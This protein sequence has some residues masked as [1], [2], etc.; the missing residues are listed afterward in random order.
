[1]LSEY[2]PPGVIINDE[3][4]VVQFRGKTA[5]YLELAPGRAS[6]NLLKML[7]EGLL[8]EVRNSV[9]QVK[10]SG[11]LVRKYCIPTKQS[12]GFRDV[13]LEVVQ[14]QPTT[15]GRHFL[16]L[17]RDSAGAAAASGKAR[18][19]KAVKDPPDQMQQE[20]IAT[21][22]YLQSIIEEQEATN[23]ELQSANEEILSS[24]EELQSINEE[25]ETAREELQSTNEELTT[26]NE[27][28]QNRNAELSQSNDDLN[29][30]LS[31]VNIA[32]VMLSSDLR[33]RRFTP[34]AGRI[35]NLIPSDIGRPITDLRS[36]IYLPELGDLIAEVLDSVTPKELEL[37]DTDGH[38][39]SLAIRPYRTSDNR[40][41]GA[42]LTL[43][44]IESIRRVGDPRPAYREFVQELVDTSEDPMAVVDEGYQVQ[45]ANPAFRA[46]V[47]VDATEGRSFP[48]DQNLKS[49]VEQ[50]ARGPVEPSPVPIELPVGERRLTVR[51]HTLP[52]VEGRE[53]LLVRIKTT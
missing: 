19:A 10:R 17:F 26:V 24:N 46:L 8:E 27:E 29:N 12:D 14:L 44:D 51:A 21:R 9:E 1:V 47:R 40:I 28:L 52:A 37:A 39:Y 32:I 22:Q 38:H 20:L 6:L 7:R 2:G 33:I 13:D 30:L 36:G 34:I 53:I 18:H 25:V 45:H 5:A 31:S 48:L 41:E 49:I 15:D 35:L 16:V 11:G 4:E 43:V 23:E 42:V 50:A 3:F